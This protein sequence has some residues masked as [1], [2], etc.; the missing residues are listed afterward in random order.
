[1]RQIAPAALVGQSKHGSQ[2]RDDLRVNRTIPGIWPQHRLFEAG[3]RVLID[4]GQ[5]DVAQRPQQSIEALQDPITAGLGFSVSGHRRREGASATTFPVPGGTQEFGFERG[6]FFVGELGVVAL[7]AAA[8][9]LTVDVAIERERA[10]V[11]TADDVDWHDVLIASIRSEIDCESKRM[12]RPSFNTFIACFLRISRSRR[13][14][15]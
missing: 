7:S 10:G 2:R 15:K 13:G 1:M 9:S 6:G 8:N 3:H 5:F 11:F 12:S 14:G 4:L